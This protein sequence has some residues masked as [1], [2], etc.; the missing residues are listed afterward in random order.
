MVRVVF[1][2][3]LGYAL[4]GILTA[5]VDAIV[6]R[7]PYYCQIVLVTDTLFTIPE[8]GDLPL[9]T[10][11]HYYSIYLLIMYPPAVWPGA[12][13]LAPRAPAAAARPD[14]A[15]SRSSPAR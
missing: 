5:A 4:I 12:T 14:E 7:G 11:P 15:Q 2:G 13:R 3:L 6:P 10:V 9:Q 8:A 1:G